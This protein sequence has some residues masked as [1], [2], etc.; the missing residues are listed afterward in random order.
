MR[1]HRCNNVKHIIF[2]DALCAD[3]KFVFQK[4]KDVFALPAPNA[5]MNLQK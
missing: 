5:K 2:T 1:N 4:V 3:R